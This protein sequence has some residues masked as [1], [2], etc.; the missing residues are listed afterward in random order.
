MK[1]FFQVVFAMCLLAIFSFASAN[2]GE[3]Y[4]EAEGIV[5]YEKGMQPNAMRRMAI[6]DAYRYLAEEVDNIRVTSKTTVKNMRDLD[7]EI[8]SNVEAVLHGARVISVTR[9]SDGSFHAKVRLPM[10]GGENS[11]AGAVLK[12]DIPIEDLI[13]KVTGTDVE[14]EYVDLNQPII[15]SRLIPFFLFICIEIAKESFINLFLSNASSFRLI[16]SFNSS[17]FCSSIDSYCSILS[18]SFQS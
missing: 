7:D 10:Y 11:L 2:A 4:I 6:L 17:K 13:L 9:Q 14:L 12:K 15:S 18:L 8:N 16:S 1:K 3:G 5:Y